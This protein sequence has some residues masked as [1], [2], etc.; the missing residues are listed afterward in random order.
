MTTREQVAL[1]HTI[2]KYVPPANIQAMVG[3][4]IE[5]YKY[6]LTHYP[7]LKKKTRFPGR[8]SCP[9]SVKKLFS[10]LLHTVAHQQL[11]LEPCPR[12][13]QLR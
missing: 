1:V 6:K 5:C 12:L 4:V 13:L 9:L 10:I 7:N 3:G 2:S 8:K 11:A